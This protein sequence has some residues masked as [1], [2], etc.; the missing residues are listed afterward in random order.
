MRNNIKSPRRAAGIKAGSVGVRMINTIAVRIAGMI[1]GI[2]IGSWSLVN[3]VS[4]L[5]GMGL[6]G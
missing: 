6:A 4:G 2:G 3:V 5:I 1:R